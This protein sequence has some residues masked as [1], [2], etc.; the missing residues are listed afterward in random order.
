[1]RKI[2][3]GLVAA[4]TV[5]APIAIAAGPASADNNKGGTIHLVATVTADPSDQGG[6][7]YSRTL[8]GT[9]DRTT[10]AFTAHGAMVTA[11]GGNYN[12]LVYSNPETVT[13]TF[14]A[15]VLTFSADYDNS[16]Y[17]WGGTARTANGKGGAFRADSTWSTINSD[18]FPEYHGAV[19]TGSVDI[20]D[21]QGNSQ[22]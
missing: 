3:I 8:D 10:G 14:K 19:M 13:G 4:T 2:I 16:S 18:G 5:A 9:Y 17:V 15:G 7:T 20:S 6:G 1:L 22:G 11:K 21:A 12:G